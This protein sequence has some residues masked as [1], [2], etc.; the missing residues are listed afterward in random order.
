MYEKDNKTSGIEIIDAEELVNEK[1][2]NMSEEEIENQGRKIAKEKKLTFVL[3]CIFSGFCTLC[4]IVLLILG[5]CIN[6]F[7]SM[8]SISIILI[9][10]S[11]SVLIATFN[12]IKP[13][14]FKWTF[15]EWFI[16]NEKREIEKV[17]KSIQSAKDT[18]ESMKLIDGKYIASATLVDTYT[19]Y[20]D[21]LHAILNYQ[22]II[23]TRM[24][25]FLVTFEDGS[26]KF[27]T[28]K[29]GSK[30]Y[31]ILIQHINFEG[32]SKEQ[33]FISN[34]DELKKYKEL[35]DMGAISQDEFDKKKKELLK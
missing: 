29:E 22:E 34:A 6:E 21:K 11:I 17:N 16:N 33:C 8:F 19:E 30:K 20:S 5:E 10:V 13:S 14:Q 7:G 28:E 23:Q 12:N 25:K 35:L 9:C 31:N 32:A 4:G 2:K 26:S 3:A 24:Y 27:Y 15:K 1:M 18:I